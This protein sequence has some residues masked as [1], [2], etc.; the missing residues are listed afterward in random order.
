[1]QDYIPVYQKKIDYET[2]REFVN[3]L[4]EPIM[5]LVRVIIIPKIPVSTNDIVD[6]DIPDTGN[7]NATSYEII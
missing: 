1:M 4:G 7:N 5:E 2:G 6:T 3:E